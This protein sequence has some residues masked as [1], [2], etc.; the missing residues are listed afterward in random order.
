MN[1]VLPVRLEEKYVMPS[2]TVTG[3]AS[4]DT[5]RRFGTTARL[6]Q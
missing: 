2:G 1:M 3:T 6:V 4:Y 5:Y